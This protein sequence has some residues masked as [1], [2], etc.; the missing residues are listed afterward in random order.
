MNV[1]LFSTVL[2][3]RSD[4]KNPGYAALRASPMQSASVSTFVLSTRDGI[5]SQ[6]A[7]R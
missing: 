5:A 1:P 7:I 3:L 4:F 2:P 6:L